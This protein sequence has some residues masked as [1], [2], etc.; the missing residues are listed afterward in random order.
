[1]RW[2]ACPALAVL[3]CLSGCGTKAAAPD[4]P[5][6]FDDK[7]CA[8]VWLHPLA[9]TSCQD[10]K[11]NWEAIRAKL[12]QCDWVDPCA[13][14]QAV[15]TAAMPVPGFDP[16]VPAPAWYTVS[17]HPITCT[18]QF[19]H[20]QPGVDAATKAIDEAVAKVGAGRVVVMGYSAGG[21]MAIR[22]GLMYGK[23]LAGIVSIS[24]HLLSQ[25]DTSWV[26]A[27]NLRTPVL[28]L[29]GRKDEVVLPAT[30]GCG[31]AALKQADVDVF[32]EQ[33]DSGHG[34]D[35]AG[36]LVSA[37]LEWLGKKA[38]PASV[39]ETAWVRG[40]GPDARGEQ[41]SLADL[42]PAGPQGES[43]FAEARTLA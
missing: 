14:A 17:Q 27:A 2:R 13:P 33:D 34:L 38:E 1:M 24:G 3:L 30:A 10:H 31:V 15:G 23:A 16:A 40:T 21:S 12:P 25:E 8:V 5:D 35:P 42:R 28:W 20:I 4:L 39:L 36:P 29:H 9:A 41:V 32:V 11:K 26:G 18:S 22:A 43:H 6:L 7:P 19:G 37:A